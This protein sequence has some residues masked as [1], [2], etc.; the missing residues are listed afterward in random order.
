MKRML[1]LSLAV[2]LCAAAA[3]CSLHA[4]NDNAREVS[5]DRSLITAADQ[6][7]VLKIPVQRDPGTER[8]QPDVITCAEPSPDI[9]RLVSETNS[10]SAQI[11]AALPIGV[12]ASAAYGFAKGHAEGAQ[13]LTDRLA[14]IQILRDGL[15]RACEAYANGAIDRNTYALVLAHSERLMFGLLMA[16]LVA[17][18]QP[19]PLNSSSAQAQIE[20]VELPAAQA[21]AAAANQQQKSAVG[22]LLKAAPGI[23][24]NAPQLLGLLT[25]GNLSKSEQDLLGGLVG[26]L[27]PKAQKLV[28]PVQAATEQVTQSGSRLQ[29][30]MAVLP[31]LAGMGGPAAPL[32][33]APLPGKPSARTV[34]GRA[35][36]PVRNAVSSS[37]AVEIMRLQVLGSMMQELVDKPTLDGMEVSCLTVLGDRTLSN[38]APHLVGFCQ[39]ALIDI[40]NTK[41]SKNG[42][43][44]E[45]ITQVRVSLP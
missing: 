20:Q 11:G 7:V 33:A 28:A 10:S 32:P 40:L 24:A 42:G 16:E 22:N 44:A 8:L 41:I 2:W 18:R 27:P 29:Q 17:G 34:A 1:L 30:L 4:V 6:R 23:V 39:A 31:L 19:Q 43:V 3:G 38:N 13:Q 21:E 26:Q 36:A 37:D 9:A 15:Y 5:N 14:T 45:R 25:K 12:S 35:Q